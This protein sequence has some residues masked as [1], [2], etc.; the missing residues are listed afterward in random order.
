MERYPQLNNQ[1]EDIPTA[2]NTPSSLLPPPN[3][4]PGVITTHSGQSVQSPPHI[5]KNYIGAVQ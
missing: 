5:V 4:S 3:K 2:T 1:K